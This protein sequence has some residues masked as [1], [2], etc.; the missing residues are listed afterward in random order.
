VEGALQVMEAQ[1][2]L[3]EA[4]V[5]RM[6]D[7]CGRQRRTIRYVTAHPDLQFVSATATEN[8]SATIKLECARPS[9]LLLR[10]AFGERYQMAFDR[11]SLL[12]V[13]EPA[14]Y[15]RGWTTTG[16][17]IIYAIASAENT[18]RRVEMEKM[19][20]EPSDKRWLNCWCRA[21]ASSFAYRKNEGMSTIRATL[22]KAEYEGVIEVVRRG[23]NQTAFRRLNVP[24]LKLLRNQLPKRPNY[25][26]AIDKRKVPRPM[27]YLTLMG[28]NVL[29]PDWISAQVSGWLSAASGH[30]I[31]TIQFTNL[32]ERDLAN[33]ALLQ[34]GSDGLTISRVEKTEADSNQQPHRWRQIKKNVAG[35]VGKEN[36]RRVACLEI[37]DQH[38][39][40]VN[41][42]PHSIK[43]T[44]P[45]PDASSYLWDEGEDNEDAFD[46]E[47]IEPIPSPP[48][49]QS[50]ADSVAVQ[51]V[52]ADP[53]ENIPY[54]LALML[55][56]WRGDQQPDLAR[57]ASILKP[58]AVAGVTA[59]GDVLSWARTNSYWNTRLMEVGA[60]MLRAKF[61]MIQS[62]MNTSSAATVTPVFSPVENRQSTPNARSEITIFHSSLG[63]TKEQK[64]D[65]GEKQ[66]PEEEDDDSF[67]P[68]RITTPLVLSKHEKAARR[69]EMLAKMNLP[70]QPTKR[71]PSNE[72]CKAIERQANEAL[73]EGYW[74]PSRLVSDKAR[75]EFLEDARDTLLTKGFTAAKRFIQGWCVERDT[76]FQSR[77]EQEC[78]L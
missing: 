39:P 1:L 11:T 20:L 55:A 47:H 42:E 29:I 44:G 15:D 46:V 33:F 14:L 30:G 59:V 35:K 51:Q 45:R 17:C 27:D 65:G 54:E 3:L 38:H 6:E 56:K 74:N 40:Q 19:G 60:K 58:L 52:V 77:E 68:Q 9:V 57:D 43:V 4:G 16:V 76:E 71:V 78:E 32:Y 26:A 23:P 64:A 34:H 18:E 10:L 53:Q 8:K 12:E 66:E 5:C 7:V 61:G 37:R 73:S 13:A 49:E 69:R 28:K 72:E 22:A 63:E 36:Q 25:A 41:P 48:R 2:F 31:A 24:A 62:K 50:P 75:D 67:V 70:K 21:G